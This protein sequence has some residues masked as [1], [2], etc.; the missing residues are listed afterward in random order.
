MKGTFDKEAYVGVPGRTCRYTGN[1]VQGLRIQLATDDVLTITGDQ[2]REIFAVLEADN[3]LNEECSGWAKCTSKPAIPRLPKRLRSWARG[4]P[5]AAYARLVSPRFWRWLEEHSVEVFGRALTEEHAACI[6]GVFGG[7]GLLA[8]NGATPEDFPKADIAS[9]TPALLGR[10]VIYEEGRRFA[11][12][13]V[14]QVDADSDRDY[15]TLGLKNLGPAAFS[16]DFPREF[17]AGGD[18]TRMSLGAGFLAGAV[19]LWLIVTGPETVRELVRIAATG[20]DRRAFLNEHR[21]LVYGSGRS[22]DY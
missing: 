6:Q 14:A 11:I 9:A 12:V 2:L 13:K 4:S 15:L 10:T 21:R 19:G 5:R 16:G 22:S 1:G 8:M 7:E 3:P 18:T 17:S 20:L